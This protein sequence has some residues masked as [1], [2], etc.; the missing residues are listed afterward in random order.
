MSF[1]RL[2]WMLAAVLYAL[3]CL[4]YAQD[5]LVK[6]PPLNSPVTD[7]T[8]T[9]SADQR[10]G[11]EAD[12][13]AFEQRKGSQVAVLIVPTTKPESIEEYAI[14]V[15]EQWKIGRKKIDDGAILVV[16]KDDRALRIEVGYG[17]EGAL[18]DATAKR[19]IED[20]IVPRFRQDDFYGGIAAGTASIMKVIDGEALPAA[21]W[22]R[23]SDALPGLRQLLPVA[24]IAAL[25]LGGILRAV[26]GRVP[27]AVAAGGIIG[28]A[29]WLLAG[30][31][32]IGLIAGMLG[33]VFTLVG[34]SRLA[35]MYLGGGHGRGG[36]GGGGGGWG[37]GGGGFGGGG[38]SGR[39]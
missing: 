28:L 23:P 31:A 10:S 29:A 24:L 38:A 2:P 30:A 15:A 8:G 9:L 11:L 27:G 5:A 37:G 39:W 22:E 33:F 35:G 1:S 17:L 7:L 21:N 19:I 25:V 13:R 14:R 3:G 32:V 18:N 12:L 34:G 36:W 16:A 6:V 4:V 26:L 20:V